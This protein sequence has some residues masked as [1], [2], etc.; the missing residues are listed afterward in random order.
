MAYVISDD[1][2]SCAACESECPVSAISEGEGKFVIAAD[3]CTDCG[4]CE[5]TCPVSAISAG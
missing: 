1:C 4:I 3:D 5:A 2:T